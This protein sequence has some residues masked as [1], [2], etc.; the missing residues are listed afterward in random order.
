VRHS[1][2]EGGDDRCSTLGFG[3]AALVSRD[4]LAGPAQSNGA[5]GANIRAHFLITV[6]AKARFQSSPM[7]VAAAKPA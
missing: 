5:K 1:K 6:R 7:V 4:E 2:R 3:R